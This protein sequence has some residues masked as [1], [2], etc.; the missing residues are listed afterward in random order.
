VIN[1]VQP[2]VLVAHTGA[3][4]HYAI[5]VLLNESGLLDHFITDVYAGS[6]S[7]LRPI[8]RLL[9]DSIRIGSITRLNGR[10]A[11]LPANKVIAFN[12]LGFLA[13]AKFHW[14]RLTKNLDNSFYI[15]Y[16]RIFQEKVTT[17]LGNATAVYCFSGQG[18]ELF[19]VA[20]QKGLICICDQ[21]SA[22][23]NYHSIKIREEAITWEGWQK[24]KDKLR[25]K[26]AWYAREA[27]EWCLADAILSPSTY[28]TDALLSEGVP[29]Q[30]IATI[31]NAVPEDMYSGRVHYYV[32]TRPL[33]IL[34]V[35]SVNLN[36]GVPY[37][38][39]ALKILGPNKI[40]AKFVGPVEIFREKLNPFLEI[41]E[42]IGNTPRTQVAP[43]YDW[44]D[45]FVL[46]SLSE[47]SATVVYEA[48]ACGLPS[49]V[50]P[51]TG[52]WIQD[53]VDGFLVPIRDSSALVEAFVKF[54]ENPQ[55]V[56][57]MS[58]NALKNA[59]NYSYEAYRQ[60]LEYIIISLH[61]Q[62]LNKPSFNE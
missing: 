48:Q 25:D 1:Q 27:E 44:A 53:G 40:Q 31:P 13:L 5:P 22:P 46:P 56:E 23:I 29:S 59:M 2:R 58:R 45:I 24:S 14:G 3:R 20:R 32:G 42:F 16:S 11:N 62:L 61:N 10:S 19:K 52:T 57:D 55:L 28:V 38:L 12:M 17:L 36:K 4:R 39:E 26:A 9:P 37:L 50:T 15:Q 47:G 51:N 49:V 33:R 35:G 60:R 21:I 43:Y 6:G 7:W 18:M 30:K 8:L 34:F 54:I 41:A